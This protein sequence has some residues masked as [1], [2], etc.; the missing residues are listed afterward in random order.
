VVTSSTGQQRAQR[1]RRRICDAAKELFLT[2]GYTTTTII[3]IARAAGV[4][5]QTVYFVFGS[6]AALLS[7]IMDGEIVGDLDPIPLLERPHVK[8][9]AQISDPVRRL[10]RVVAVSCDITQ[11]LAPLYEIVRSGAAEAEVREL[12]DRHEDQR[13][14]SHRA[15]LSMLEDALPSGLDPDEAADRLYALLSHEVFWL[16]VHRRGWSARQWRQYVMNEAVRQILT[17]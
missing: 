6:K 13:W 14:H 2:Q 9:I 15:L 5:H 1:T 8:R 3:D 17:S 12:L 7:A 16:L 10:H 11:R 4:A